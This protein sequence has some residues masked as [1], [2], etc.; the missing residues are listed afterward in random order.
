MGFWI[1][2][3]FKKK[4]SHG[5]K[6]CRTS[7][8]P[9]VVLPEAR[10]TLNRIKKCINFPKCRKI[11][12]FVFQNASWLFEHNAKM[13]AYSQS[14]NL[15]LF[16]YFRQPL[17][18]FDWQRQ[19]HVKQQLLGGLLWELDSAFRFPGVGTYIS[20]SCQFSSIRILSYLVKLSG[21]KAEVCCPRSILSRSIFLR[22][23]DYL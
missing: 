2:K 19:S 20:L 5:F 15:H 22:F 11:R 3:E 13:T 8:Q 12:E 18:S 23:R 1:A 10:F 16:Q 6:F 7:Y 14:F 21:I 9:A 4:Y 17:A